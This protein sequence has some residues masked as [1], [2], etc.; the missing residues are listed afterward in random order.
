MGRIYVICGDWSDYSLSLI[1]FHK[2]SVT[3]IHP[4]HKNLVVSAGKDNRLGCLEH[5]H[6][7]YLQRKPTLLV[8]RE[9]AFITPSKNILRIFN[10]DAQDYSIPDLKLQPNQ[11]YQNGTFHSKQ[12]RTGC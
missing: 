3:S 6:Q 4:I 8:A 11:I 2:G 1:G 7:I 5:S 10:K 9:R 12:R